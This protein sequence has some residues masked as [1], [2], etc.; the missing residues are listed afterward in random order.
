MSRRQTLARQYFPD[1]GK[2]LDALRARN[3]KAGFMRLATVMHKRVSPEAMRWAV[4]R[5]LKPSRAAAANTNQQQLRREP[6]KQQPQSQNGA[7]TFKFVAA[8]PDTWDVDYSYPG[9]KALL[10]ENKAVLKDGSKVQWRERK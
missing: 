2:K 8:E 9:I 10:G 4:A 1:Q 7:G 5:I 6:A 3:D